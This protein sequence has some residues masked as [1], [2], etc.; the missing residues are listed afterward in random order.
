VD[1]AGDML[2][3]GVRYQLSE[4]GLLTLFRV[5]GTSAYDQVDEA[6]SRRGKFEPPV[7]P[8]ARKGSR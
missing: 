2:I 3:A 7:Q 4:K 6:Y 1:I 8:K 5:V